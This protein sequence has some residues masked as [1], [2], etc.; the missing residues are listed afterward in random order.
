MKSQEPCYLDSQGHT[1]I[2]FLTKNI[3][4]DMKR[5]MINGAFDFCGPF[6]LNVNKKELK[7]ILARSI[8]GALIE[9]IQ[10]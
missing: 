1:C 9:L 8:G 10:I 4:E 6:K 7:I 3:E 2:A 5:M